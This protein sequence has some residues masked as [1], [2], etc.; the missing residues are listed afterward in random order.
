MEIKALALTLP[1]PDKFYVLKSQRANNAKPLLWNESYRDKLFSMQ[2]MVTD[3]AR[4]VEEFPLSSEQREAMLN[5][6]LSPRKAEE[7]IKCVW[8][9]A[10]TT[11]KAPMFLDGI[12][13]NVTTGGLAGYDVPLGMKR[14]ILINNGVGATLTG[15]VVKELEKRYRQ[16][17]LCYD[18]EGKEVPVEAYCP[19]FKLVDQAGVEVN[20]DSPAIR[21]NNLFINQMLR[22]GNSALTD[23]K[24][25]RLVT[26]PFE[27]RV[28]IVTSKGREVLREKPRQWS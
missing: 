11:R 6:E 13:D 25:L 9:D 16:T 23:E 2:K 3:I 14:Y 15:V 19:G 21:S 5:T 22:F 7:S 24:T 26:I 28:S 27:P 12:E 18:G 20:F 4:G 8:L 1:N 10:V 17:W